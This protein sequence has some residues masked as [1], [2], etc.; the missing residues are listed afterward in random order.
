MQHP[1]IVLAGD[2]LEDLDRLALYSQGMISLQHL[3][4]AENRSSGDHKTLP[5]ERI[6]P[7]GNLMQV[8]HRRPL[9][10][11]NDLLLGM[12]R[13]PSERH[14]VF[15][16]YQSTQV[17]IVSFHYSQCASIP[18]SPNHPLGVRWDQ[19]AM[20][21]VFLPRPIDKDDRVVEGAAG[22]LV[23]PHYY[24]GIS[25]LRHAKQCAKAR[26]SHHQRVLG[27]HPKKCLGR[28]VVPQGSIGRI[29]QPNRIARQPGL[30]KDYHFCPLTCCLLNQIACLGKAF[31]QV[32]V[33]RRM[34]DHRHLDL[35]TRIW[36]HSP[37]PRSHCGPTIATVF[38]SPGSYRT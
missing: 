2:R 11:V 36:S 8:L 6:V 18:P 29:I 23:R 37:P 16:A 17:P 10:H 13:C 14:P 1:I 4:P 19:L 7:A 9:S 32:Q 25:F 27:Q 12:H 26:V 38:L 3:A 21:A 30:W 22:T 31:R 34:L 20:Q 35:I 24:I 5:L 15:P 33:R 28:W